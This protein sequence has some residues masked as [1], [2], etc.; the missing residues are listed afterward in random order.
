[1]GD[2]FFFLVGELFGGRNPNDLGINRL[3]S[4]HV[5]GKNE[6]QTSV[7][8]FLIWNNFILSEDSP[9]IEYTESGLSVIDRYHVIC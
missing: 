5:G 4:Q 7:L 1:M 8:G 9:P 3:S 2:G 6:T